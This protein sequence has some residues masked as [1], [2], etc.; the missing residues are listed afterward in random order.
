MLNTSPA[1]WSSIPENKSLGIGALWRLGAEHLV[2]TL[3]TKFK[4]RL[5]KVFSNLLHV[6]PFGPLWIAGLGSVRYIIVQ[7]IWSKTI[8]TES[9]V[10][11]L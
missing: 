7:M 5:Y 2:E 8:F 6:V 3:Y 9:E 11:G 1:P 4:L 10:K